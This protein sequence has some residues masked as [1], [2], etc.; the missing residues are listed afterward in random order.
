MPAHLNQLRSRVLQTSGLHMRFPYG[1]RFPKPGNNHFSAQL[2]SK[3][4]DGY[5]VRGFFYAAEASA[6]VSLFKVVYNGHHEYYVAAKVVKTKLTCMSTGWKGDYHEEKDTNDKDS[7]IPVPGYY[8]VGLRF[9]KNKFLELLRNDKEYRSV[10]MNALNNYKWE[11]H[12]QGAVHYLVS[13]HV[14]LD[15]DKTPTILG[16]HFYMYSPEC[17]ITSYWYMNVKVENAGSPLIVKIKDDSL[18]TEFPLKNVKQGDVVSVH[19]RSTRGGFLVSI[20]PH[21]ATQFIT[22][23]PGSQNYIYPIVSDNCHVLRHYAEQGSER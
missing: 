14:S 2:P 9:S 5:T 17:G 19:I 20:T 8:T 1:A 7:N 23:P 21:G 6:T 11:L 15:T 12:M 18:K 22:T 13:L 3:Y 10:D 4:L 16:R